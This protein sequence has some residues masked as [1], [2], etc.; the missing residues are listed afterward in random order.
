MKL[1]TKLL[2]GPY[3]APPDLLT[4]KQFLKRI[5]RN[6]PYDNSP[7]VLFD[8]F[9]A[10]GAIQKA[11][12]S[13]PFDPATYERRCATLVKGPEDTVL[14]TALMYQA[15]QSHLNMKPPLQLFYDLCTEHAKNM[16]TTKCLVR[17][18]PR[19]WLP[20]DPRDFRIFESNR[21]V[22]LA[23]FNPFRT[24]LYQISRITEEQ[25]VE[26]CLDMIANFGP[27]SEPYKGGI[28]EDQ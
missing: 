11:S 3:G 10:H 28:G 21:G 2:N 12:S 17:V 7:R 23:C 13:F 16:G 1:K 6:L 24:T 5:P 18:G 26:A 22:A 20:A 4:F 9:I 15:T 19:Q 25:M 8:A 27:Y 14:L